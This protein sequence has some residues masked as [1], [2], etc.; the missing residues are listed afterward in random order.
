MV[1][2]NFTGI[3]FVN[4]QTAAQSGFEF[5]TGAIEDGPTLPVGGQDEGGGVE[6]GGEQD[7]Q[8]TS[9]LLQQVMSSRLTSHFSYKKGT[10]RSLSF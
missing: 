3:F 7:E 8:E 6:E 10:H 9:T 1:L 5:F 4:T 2:L